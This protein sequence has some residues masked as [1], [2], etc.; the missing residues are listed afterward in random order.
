MLCLNLPGPLNAVA[1]SCCHGHLPFM[2][3]DDEEE[4]TQPTT[5][6]SSKFSNKMRKFEDIHWHNLPN[7]AKKAA[8]TLG[9]DKE[10][11]D[12]SGMFS[13]ITSKYYFCIFNEILHLTCAICETYFC[14]YLPR[15][16]SFSGWPES[17][18][19]WWEDLTAAEREAAIEL[20]Y[21]Q[22]SWDDQYEGKD[23]DELPRDVKRAAA[24][25]GFNKEMWGEDEWPD[26]TDE[27]W[28]DLSP[29]VRSGAMVLGY[30]EEIWG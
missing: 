17:E 29:E 27:H 16:F 25:M 12:N 15:G 14:M 5:T 24:A 18:D 2:F 28:G 20:G 3:N 26:C 9:F 4:T 23:W 1:K 21:D 6:P 22:A 13:L 7:K 30:N 10:S 8:T 19:K 11:W